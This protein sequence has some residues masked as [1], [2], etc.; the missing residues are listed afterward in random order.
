MTT[1]I[2]L[3]KKMT[4]AEGIQRQLSQTNILT[5][6]HALSRHSMMNPQERAKLIWIHMFTRNIHPYSD[7]GDLYLNLLNSNIKLFLESAKSNPPK[8]I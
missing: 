4:F 1:E 3:C 8:D 6:S 5:I 7:L 2:Q